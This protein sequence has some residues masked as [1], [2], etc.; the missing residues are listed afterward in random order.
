MYE[1]GFAIDSWMKS[2]SEPWFACVAYWDI[3]S[4]SGP[5]VPFVPA[6]VNLWQPPHPFDLKSA[7]PAVASPLAAGVA[8][9][10]VAGRLPTTVSAVGDTTPL[11][12]QQA[13]RNAS[14]RNGSSRR[15]RC[16]SLLEPPGGLLASREQPEADRCQPAPAHD[17]RRRV[18][19]EQ[20]NDERHEVGVEQRPPRSET[21]EHREPD[22]PEREQECAVPGVRDAGRRDVEPVAEVA[23]QR[24]RPA[25][26]RLR[27]V[28]RT[29][30]SRIDPDQEQRGAGGRRGR[31]CGST[32]RQMP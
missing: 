19:H 14:A 9:V 21:R 26:D 1:L 18:V 13:S 25:A 4:R 31:E 6:G 22:H 3:L 12:P 7:A 23:E 24:A 17:V 16:A 10:V 27:D 8:E 28:A 32:G 15:I 29:A 30:G 2:A 20:R 11:L 5:T